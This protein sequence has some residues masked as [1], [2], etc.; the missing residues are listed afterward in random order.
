MQKHILLDT[1]ATTG[2][3]PPLRIPPGS[4]AWMPVMLTGITI[5]TVI[6]EAASATEQEVGE[7]TADWAPI[8]GASWTADGADG[9]TT[10]FPW[11][12]AN[13][14]DYTSGAITVT[15]DI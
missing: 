4:T 9:L 14:T 2:A 5:A 3:G 15:I 12:R 11:I 8:Y 7:G 1:V 6:L 10:A 13:V